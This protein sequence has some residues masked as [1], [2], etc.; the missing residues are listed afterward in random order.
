MNTANLP[1]LGEALRTHLTARRTELSLRL[2]K[3]DRDL[4]HQSQPLSADFD[5][6]AVE[7]TNDEVLDAISGTVR[8]ELEQIDI[9]LSRLAAGQYSCCSVCGADIEPGRLAAVPYTTKCSLCASD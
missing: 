8:E 4:R 5:E 7:R 3:V 6:Q 9:A 1:E 2:D